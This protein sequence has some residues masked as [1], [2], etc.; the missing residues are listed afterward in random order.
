MSD[1]ASVAGMP[2]GSTRET[3]LARAQ[4]PTN[5]GDGLHVLPNDALLSLQRSREPSPGELVLRET[6]DLF[7]GARRILCNP[8]PRLM[9]E[10]ALLSGGATAELLRSGKWISGRL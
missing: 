5:T 9:N 8:S 4:E 1:F 6:P 3:G 7:Q 10:Q 2:G